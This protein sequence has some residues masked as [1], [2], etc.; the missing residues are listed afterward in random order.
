M[1]RRLART[2]IAGFVATAA[3]AFAASQVFD[4]YLVQ[5][6]G[7]DLS[8][9]DANER[10]ALWINAYNAW[11][12]RLI[13]DEGRPGSIRDINKTLGFLSTGGAWRIRFAQVGGG[14]WTLDEIEREVIRV[15]FEEPRIH[16]AL[17]CAAVGC[18]PLRAEAYTGA[19]FDRQLDEQAR[20]WLLRSP[21]KN[22]G[23]VEERRVY[24]SRIFDWYEEDFGGGREEL[25]RYLTPWF[26]GAE[27]DFL[28]SGGFRLECT[29]YDWALNRKR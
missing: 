21:T 5:L 10:L 9:L 23:V 25:G 22:R 19:E 17:V 8:G 16:F 11:T 18:P 6:A 27:A 20:A 24:L 1:R 2:L 7:A 26:D 14:V 12:I 13:N 28:R 4:T 3:S 15:R 29:D